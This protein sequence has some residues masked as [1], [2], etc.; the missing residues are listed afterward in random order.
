M[1]VKRII[2][3]FAL[4]CYAHTAQA[5]EMAIPE[6]KAV[7]ATVSTYLNSLGAVV[8]DFTQIDA[9]GATAEGKFFLKRPGKLRWQYAPPVPLLIVANGSIIA[10]QDFEL[11]QVSR[12]SSKD[13]LAAFLARDKIELPDEDVL[14]ESVTRAKGALRITL[15]QKGKEKDGALTLVF[16]ESP[17]LLKK[18]EV[19]DSANRL[20]SISLANIQ[21]DQTLP[22][23]LFY[24]DELKRLEKK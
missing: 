15:R 8:A 14:I 22:D 13:T 4:L 23:S 18:I 3:A 5:A 20:T 2:L 24:V 9:N 12:I 17:M 11:N 7:L 19:T 6:K 1:A 21:Q 16:D 10:Y